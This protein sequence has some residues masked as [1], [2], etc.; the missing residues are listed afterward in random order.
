MDSFCNIMRDLVNL[1]RMDSSWAIRAHC[2]CLNLL[3]DL[4]SSISS[5]ICW[6][7]VRRNSWSYRQID[8]SAS[9]RR[10]SR[11]RSQTASSRRPKE[12]VPSC[13]VSLRHASRSPRPWTSTPARPSTEDSTRW[14]LMGW[15]MDSDN[16]WQS[17]HVK[18]MWIIFFNRLND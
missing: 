17:R 16:R 5:N 18:T 3:H 2:L 8:L 6:F 10:L 14:D 13:S 1:P 7:W 4:S 12:T 9:L 11:E 15:D